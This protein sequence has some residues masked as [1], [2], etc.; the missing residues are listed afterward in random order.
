MPER[1][2]SPPRF[3]VAARRTDKPIGPTEALKVGAALALRGEEF[4]VVI[5]VRRVFERSH[6]LISY[7]ANIE[8]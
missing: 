4:V 2:T 1:L 5:F 7:M 8:L 6:L 3:S